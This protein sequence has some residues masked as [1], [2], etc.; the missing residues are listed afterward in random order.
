MSDVVFGCFAC[1]AF[2]VIVLFNVGFLT[3]YWITIQEINT[4]NSSNIST[5]SLTTGTCHHGVL[6]SLDCPDSDNVFDK[7]LVAVNIATSVCLTTIPLLWC[8]ILRITNNYDDSRILAD[9]CCTFFPFFYA[10]GG[11]L[12]LVSAIRVTAKFDL[13]L[14]GWSFFLTVAATSIILLQNVILL[15][16]CICTRNKKE[17]CTIFL[18]YRRSHYSAV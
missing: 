5:Q 14:L 10:V 11:L 12:G 2:V 15:T 1:I 3:P 18:V 4:S 6:Y 9:I 16:Y 13:D 8:F 17:K 7:I